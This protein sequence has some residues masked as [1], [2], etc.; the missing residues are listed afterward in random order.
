MKKI[1]VIGESCRDIF[2]YCKAERLAPDVPIP[3]LRVDTDHRIKRIHIRQAPLHTYELIAIS[4]YNKGYLTEGDIRYIC[5]N[6]SNVFIDTKKV[7]GEWAAKAK[8]IKINNYEYERSKSHISD[9][10][11]D[12]IIVTKGAR[13]ATFQGNLYPVPRKVEVR[14]S[15]GAGDSFFAALVVHYAK[16]GDIEKAITFANTCASTVVQLKGVSVIVER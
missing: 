7:L 2:V 4:D 6:H 13:G 9:A 11:K 15:S 16:S 14:D 12:K 3:V 8:Y 5:E 1:L 10:L